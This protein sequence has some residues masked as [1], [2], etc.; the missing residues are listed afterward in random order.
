V[1]DHQVS[2]L[3]AVDQNDP[4]YRPCELNG[5]L[6]KSGRRDEHPSIRP[7]PSQSAVKRLNFGSTHRALP[8]LGLDVDLFEA[9]PVER[10]H[11]VDSAIAGSPDAKEVGSPCAV[12]QLVEEVQDDSL[13][14]RG[15][16]LREQV[17][18]V[19]CNA[20]SQFPKRLFE[21]I[22]WANRRFSRGRWLVRC[23][24]RLAARGRRPYSRLFSPN[25][26]TFGS[27]RRQ[28]SRVFVG[29]SEPGLA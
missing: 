19:R 22:V 25:T 27:G 29:E 13:E 17:D 7:L 11:A 6:G 8:S 23:R 20:R 24:L 10:N 3:R 14:V 1:I 5:L 9:E 28:R 2:E 4:F 18:E 15:R 26:T 16:H 12:S 21:S